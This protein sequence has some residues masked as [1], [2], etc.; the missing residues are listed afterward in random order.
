MMGEILKALEVH[1]P[2]INWSNHIHNTGRFWNMEGAIIYSLIRATN[3]KNIL[4]LGTE[5]GQSTKFLGEAAVKNDTRVTTIEVNPEHA[6]IAKQNLAYLP[7]DV[8][9]MECRDY[10]Y[11]DSYDFILYD[12]AHHDFMVD[13]YKDNLLTRLHGWFATHD[14]D[15]DNPSSEKERYKELFKGK[16]VTT[17]DIMKATSYRPP[18]EDADSGFMW[19]CVYMKI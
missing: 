7:V 8:V 16:Y 12:A 5:Y 9:V 15:T 6:V 13:W 3:A 11:L 18:H 4:E 10:R 1:A 19:S 17:K 2:E 14:I